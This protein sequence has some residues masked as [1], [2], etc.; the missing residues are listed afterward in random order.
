MLFLGISF[1]WCI[2]FTAKQQ[3][4]VRHARLVFSSLLVAYLS[5]VLG[6]DKDENRAKYVVS[7]QEKISRNPEQAHAI[8]D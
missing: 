2:L 4:I 3:V 5:L 1:N 7:K 8:T 6:N